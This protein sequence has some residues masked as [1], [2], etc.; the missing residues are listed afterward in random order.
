MQVLLI[1]LHFVV[2]LPYSVL[3]VIGQVILHRRRDLV[4]TRGDTIR[5]VRY[6]ILQHVRRAV[7]D[8]VLHTGGAIPLDLFRIIPQSIGN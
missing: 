5:Q 3:R 1:P 6:T 4:V 8:A 2:H 7:R